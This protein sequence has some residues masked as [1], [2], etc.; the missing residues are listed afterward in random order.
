MVVSIVHKEGPQPYMSQPFPK[1]GADSAHL[2]LTA[3]NPH[4]LLVINHLQLSSLAE[5]TRTLALYLNNPLKRE[6]R[7]GRAES[8]GQLWLCLCF[9]PSWKTS[10]REDM[11]GPKIGISTSLLGEASLQTAQGSEHP[12]GQSASC[13]ARSPATALPERDCLTQA[14]REGRLAHSSAISLA[15]QLQECVEELPT[16]SGWPQNTEQ[17]RVGNDLTGYA[18]TLYVDKGYVCNGEKE[19]A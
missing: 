6:P 16:L 2:L 17:S 4:A 11:P 1:Q 18:G 3:L 13:R 9:L 19:Q 10:K 12:K 5:T 14:G 15:L 8:E 7:R